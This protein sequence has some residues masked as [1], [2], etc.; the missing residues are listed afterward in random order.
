MTRTRRGFTLVE[1]MLSMTVA[2]VVITAATSFSMSSWQTRRGWTVREGVDRGAR[3]I[4]LALAR[5]VQ[6]AGISM[7]STPTFASLGSF[8]D[9][10]SVLSVPYTPNEAPVYSIFDDGGVDPTY[11]PGG[12]CG[13]LCIEFNKPNGALDLVAGDLARL[14]VGTTRR[15]LLLSSVADQGNGRFRVEFL[16]VKRLLGRDAGLDSL[17]LSRSGSTLQKLNAVVYY[18][19]P[20]SKA[21]YRATSFDAG[22]LP[23]GQL[24]ASDVEAFETSLLF[25]NGSESPAY[26][27][28]DADT[29]NDGNDIM[30]TRIRAQLKSDRS[31]PA[32]NGGQPI[33][34]WYEW[35]VSPRNLMY[36]KNRTN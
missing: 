19:N 36:E 9:T 8:G 28:L 33:L 4:G 24:M 15:L 1:L 31:D 27:G 30:G 17:L 7:E 21:L 22:G 34:R 10:L 6:E 2:I 35:Q 12:N 23:V 14:Q 26:N 5:D 20:S 18:R 16:D 11:P 32:V 29:L 25:I 13:P 3:F